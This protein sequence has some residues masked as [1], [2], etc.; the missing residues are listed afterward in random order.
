MNSCRHDHQIGFAQK[1]D[2]ITLSGSRLPVCPHTH[3]AHERI[4]AVT[5]RAPEWAAS[6]G[7]LALLN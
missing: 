7:Q 5:S 2:D 6:V 1:R 4:H 3:S